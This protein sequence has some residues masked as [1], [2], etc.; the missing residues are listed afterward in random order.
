ME[1]TDRSGQS[2]TE[3]QILADVETG[4]E[5][6]ARR[7]MADWSARDADRLVSYLA[8]DVVY[9]VYEGGPVKRGLEEVRQALAGFMDRWRRIEF[10][11][12]RLKVIG[13]LVINERS[14][15]Y[16][17]KNGQPDWRFFVAGLFVFRNGKIELWRDYSLPGK[18]QIFGTSD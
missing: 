6:L 2:V 12:H 15:E 8:E 3:T 13:P 16:D 1:T 17:G 9:M 5:A 7:F 11:V 18:K 14:E 10:K 4:N